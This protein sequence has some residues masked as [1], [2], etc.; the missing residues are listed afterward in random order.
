ME[1]LGIL[2]SYFFQNPFVGITVTDRDGKC[3]MVNHA[4]TRIT[5][6]PREKMLGRNLR[7]MVDEHVFSVSSTIKV[8]ETGKEVN[9][10]QTTSSGSSYEVK[11]VPVFGEDGR[12]D[13][14][15]SYLID[16]NMAEEFC[17][18]VKQI[19]AEKERAADPMPRLLA[20][21]KEKS[22]IVYSSKRMEELLDFA[23]KIA[24]SEATVLITGQSGTGKELVAGLIHENSARHGKPFIKLNCAAIPENLLESELFGYEP[25]AFTGSKR[26]GSRG[27]FVAANGGSLFLDEIGEMPL[28][29]QAKLL[30]VLQEQEVMRVGSDKVVKVDVRI[31]AA[32]NSSLLALMQ[33]KRFREDLYYRL[34]VINLRI[35]SLDEHKEDIPVLIAH[36][37]YEYNQKYGFNKKITKDALDF[38]SSRKYPGN[39]RELKNI[40]ERL[41]LQS[42]SDVIGINDAFELYGSVHVTGSRFAPAE[43]EDLGSKSLK[44]LMDDYEKQVL[45]GFMEVY[46]KPDE[47]ARRLRIDRSTLSR[48]LHKHGL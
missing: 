6:I 18:L 43:I 9:L 13:Y 42:G 17:C 47:A 45:K 14:I 31:I 21:A 7:R 46:K 23:E 19:D 40:I 1:H 35:P 20:M 24:G 22:G 3:I 30:R 39:V 2:Q 27:I 15:V 36:F 41:V 25:G 5:G 28:Q 11:G 26:E 12:I 16:A 10:H 37:I 32:T 44:E 8:L 48:K 38:L 29:L 33:E 4:Q 34:N